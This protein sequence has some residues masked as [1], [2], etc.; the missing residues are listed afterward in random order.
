MEPN[1]PSGNTEF[2]ASESLN[3]RHYWHV[4]L[5]RRW[6]VITAFISVF[7]LSIIYLVKAT[8]IYQATATLQINKESNSVM[9]IGAPIVF[10]SND[11]EYLQTQY[12]NLLSRSLIESVVEDLDLKKDERYSQA[13]DTVRAVQGDITISPVRLSRLVEVSVEHP[14]PRVAAEIVNK[15]LQNFLALNQDQ[16]RDRA[17]DSY[18]FLTSQ[19][20]G[21]ANDVRQARRAVFDFRK[22]EQMP[23]LEESQNTLKAQLDQANANYL[24]AQEEAVQAQQRLDT[25]NNLI[26][27]M[28]SENRELDIS[29]IPEIASSVIIQGLRIDRARAQAELAKLEERYLEKWPAVKEAKEQIEEY[30][31][32]IQEQAQYELEALKTAARFSRAKADRAKASYELAQ[33]EMSRLNELK[34][35]YDNLVME[36]EQSE[37][38]YLTMLGKTK[39][40]DLNTKDMYQNLVIVDQ[41]IVP[42]NPVKP[43]KALTLLLGMIGGMGL[44]FALAFFANYLDDSVKS[45]D[46]VET[47]LKLNFLGYIPNIK[48]NSLVERD[49]QAHLHP[50]SNAAEGFRTVRAAISLVHKSDKFKV[51]AFTSTIPSEGKSLV[52]SNL[53]IVTAQTGVRTLLIDADLRRPSMHKAFQMQSPVGLSAYLTGQVTDVDEII[54]KTEIPNLDIMC[55]GAVPDNPS[56]LVGSKKMGELLNA[57]RDKYD[58]VFVDCPPVSAV[59]DPLMVASRT[60][61]IVFVT[62]FN[63]IRRD[64][65]RRTI[66]RIQDAGVFILGNVIND[67]DF[68]GKDSYY[69]SYYYYQNRYYASYYSN[70]KNQKGGKSDKGNLATK[71]KGKKDDESAA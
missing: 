52:T 28:K 31:N 57:V 45:Q 58:R 5:E 53:A 60:D 29:S 35:E 12:K 40:M 24:Q 55:C 37:Q 32:R 27:E 47:Y 16:K 63:K 50:Q 33:R 3:L 18:N 68:E 14:S 9:D 23:S 36:Q 71:G 11:Q 17:L 49:Q 43:R 10:N 67:I 20:Q 19:V 48:S 39:E 66:Q 54:H 2:S 1:A 61:G 8:P 25:V 26:A 22:K 34:V 15:L 6:L 7:I 64:H 42:F 70:E 65:A 21:L 51:L 41:A 56:E 30:T 69:Y 44:G 46:D 38:I 4:M 13:Q 62:K 59:S